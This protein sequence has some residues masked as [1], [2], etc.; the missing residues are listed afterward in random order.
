ML[1][2]LAVRIE[3]RH[4]FLV[5]LHGGD[6]GFLRHGEEAAL[7]AAGDRHR[8]LGEIGDLVQQ[9]IVETRHAAGF[10]RRTCHFVAHALAA[11]GRIGQHLGAAHGVEPAVGI[12][13]VHRLR[14]HE[15]VAA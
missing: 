13:H 10:L 6:Q 14:M 15:T 8:P 4:E 1:G 11:L 7:E 2:E 9:G 3:H 5:G 12:G